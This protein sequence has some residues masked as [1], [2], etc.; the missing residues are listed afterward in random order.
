MH[1]HD[2]IAADYSTYY[3]MISGTSGRPGDTSDDV[4]VDRHVPGGSR[5]A[6]MLNDSA[7]EC[8]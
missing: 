1:S 5:A 2:K 7:R 8:T 4:M 3:V 6:C